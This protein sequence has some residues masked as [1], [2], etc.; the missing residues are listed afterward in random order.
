LTV[1]R[2]CGPDGG[3]GL[4]CLAAIGLAVARAG[5]RRARAGKWVVGIQF[6]P[7]ALLRATVPEKAA[8]VVGCL[9]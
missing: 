5:C 9:R 1:D 7:G 6:E 2:F 4:P 3:G 8:A